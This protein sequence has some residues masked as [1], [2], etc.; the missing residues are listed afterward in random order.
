[1]AIV[2][3]KEVREHFIPKKSFRKHLNKAVMFS[4]YSEGFCTVSS[5]FDLSC[6]Y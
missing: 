5:T 6:G 1:M 4:P 3:Q 2:V